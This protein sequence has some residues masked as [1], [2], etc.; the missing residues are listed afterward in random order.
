MK[1]VKRMSAMSKKAC[2]IT[3]GELSEKFL[4]A[5]LDKHPSEL[6]IVVDGAL[7]I[8]HGLGVKPDFIVGDF[9]TV[10]QELLEHYEKDII[11]R[12]P[13]EKDQTDTEL[14]IET[15]LNSGCNHLVFFGATGSR[16]DHSLGNIFLLERMVK[17]GVSAEL[18]NENNR[19]Y[20]KNQSFTLQRNNT[21]G[22]YLSLLPLSETV[23]GVTL[24][25][26]KYPVER[27][28]FYRD[29]TLGISN[30]IT[31]EEARVEFSKGTF[32]VVESKDK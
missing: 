25:G 30:E 19:L 29:C 15:A 14:A 31:A 11:L 4:A 27:L 16:L 23:E 8:T 13:P 1:N 6:R 7:E 24:T 26:F 5:Y 21:W 22:D 20:L 28:T 9:D 10:N 2:I 3:G 32:I 17:Q 12:H 18:L